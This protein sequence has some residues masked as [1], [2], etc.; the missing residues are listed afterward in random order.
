[1]D[2]LKNVFRS[3]R[4]VAKGEEE[5]HFNFPKFHAIT[6]Y[7]DYIKRYGCADGASTSAPEACHKYM[8]K[9]FYKLTNMK[10]DYL[11]QIRHHNTQHTNV[12]AMEDNLTTA[13]VIPVAANPDFEQLRNTRVTRRS[14]LS[15]LSGNPSHRSAWN[16]AGVL[17]Q[18]AGGYSFLEAV[19]QF[20]K[21][22]R[23]RGRNRVLDQ[24]ELSEEGLDWVTNY[25]ISFHP[26]LTCWKPDG[27]DSENPEN[28]VQ[29]KLRCAPVW[30][31]EKD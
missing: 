4:P 2:L 8:V 5:G 30:Q 21:A 17:A 22:E 25:I 20:I 11:Q 23:A 24:G 18:Y 26:S 31:G 12:I 28:E 1:M 16:S 3:Y 19:A 13:M 14:T 10:K 29:E 6:H 9:C 15:A 7:V 27:R